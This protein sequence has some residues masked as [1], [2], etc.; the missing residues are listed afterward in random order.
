M[1]PERLPFQLVFFRY[2]K[3]QKDIKMCAR[4]AKK[5]TK[6]SGKAKPKAKGKSSK[7]AG[8]KKKPAKKGESKSSAKPKPKAKPKNKPKPK[9]KPKPKTQTKSKPKKDSKKSVAVERTGQ[10][11]SVSFEMSESHR[12][13]GYSL[14]VML[15]TG[16]PG[17]DPNRSGPSLAI[18]VNDQPYLVDFGPGIVRRAAAA[19]QQGIYGLSTHLLDTAFL[20]HLHSDHTAGYADL[21]LTPWVCGREA[22]LEVYG[23]PGLKHMTDH[24]VQAYAADIDQRLN[25][26]EPSSKTGHEVQAFEVQPGKVYEDHNVEVHAFEVWHG[27]GW[28]C[29]GYKFIC[30]DRTIVVSGDTCKHENVIEAAR[31]CDVL[32]HEV[33]SGEGVK[34]RSPEWRKYHSTYHT[35]GHEL[36]E[37]ANEAQ[38]GLV[39]L[40]HQLHQGV[41]DAELIR[42]VR[43]GYS[44]SV[45]SGKDLDVF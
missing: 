34:W 1:I 18:V 9:D 14:L 11:E 16:T 10:P 8:K 43:S 6:S 19:E 45:V 27:D 35:L 25:G 26:L 33:C 3:R 4:K 38:P 42:E 29:Y 30:P 32:V 17:P 40:T 15:G 31:G 21:M 2:N 20:T 36:A 23:P 37:I 7:D 44:G 5:K 22:P 24:L 28:T 12:R 41:S 39:V 13:D